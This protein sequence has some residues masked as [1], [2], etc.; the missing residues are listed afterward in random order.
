MKTY[1]LW[2]ML[3]AFAVGMVVVVGVSYVGGNTLQGRLSIK[4]GGGYCSTTNCQ[5]DY[6]LDRLLNACGGF[7][8]FTESWTSFTEQWTSFTSQWS[9]FTESVKESVDQLGKKEGLS[10]KSLFFMKKK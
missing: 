1:K 6:K 2:Q 10:L 9:S 4:G 7:N 8:S 5:L 3:V